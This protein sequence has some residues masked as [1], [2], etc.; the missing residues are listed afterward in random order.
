MVARYKLS[1]P[2]FVAPY[3]LE[4]G[5]VIDTDREPS[6]TWV[7]MNE[8]AAA[9]MSKLYNKEY[10][11]FNEKGDK[12]TIRPH[13]IKEA[14]NQPGARETLPIVT[15]VSAAPRATTE[16]MGLAEANLSRGESATY[17]D[18]NGVERLRI[19]QP[20]PVGA[21]ETIAADQPDYKPPLGSGTPQPPAEKVDSNGLPI[22]PKA[23]P[24]DRP[25]AGDQTDDGTTVVKPAA[26]P[27]PT[28][29]APTA[30]SASPK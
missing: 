10:E 17:V 15:V 25:E 18:E 8:E 23:P 27:L 11:V 19:A 22:R 5:T 21:P 24:E 26:P 2:A 20:A 14:A 12:V 29:Q 7:P 6:I 16:M 3:K 1:Q 9:A 28:P 4:A 13:K 30:P